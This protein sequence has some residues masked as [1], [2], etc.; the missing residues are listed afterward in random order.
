[1][2][3]GWLSLKGT[4]RDSRGDLS[5]QKKMKNGWSPLGKVSLKRKPG[6]DG[7]SGAFPH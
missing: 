3:V 7:V 4:F 5:G 6:M 2:L 1:M